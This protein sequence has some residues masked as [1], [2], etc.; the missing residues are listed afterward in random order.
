MVDPDLAMWET[1]QVKAP[2]DPDKLMFIS[3]KALDPDLTIWATPKFG[4]YKDPTTGKK[5]VDP[6]LA[7]W[8]A[9][10]P[11]FTFGLPTKQ[12]QRET[13]IQRE[14]EVGVRPPRGGIPSGLAAPWIDVGVML[15]VVPEL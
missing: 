10:Q 12:E 14:V 8:M 2:L 4:I 3:Q 1:A 13:I 9:A 5:V 11:K 7:M 15:G 6:D